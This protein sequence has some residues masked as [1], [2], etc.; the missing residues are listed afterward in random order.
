M[1]NDFRKYPGNLS[2]TV[3]SYKRE[4]TQSGSLMC[5][6]TQGSDDEE[7]ETIH[8]NKN[9]EVDAK[10]QTNGKELF[11]ASELESRLPGKVLKIITVQ[12]H[13]S[14]IFSIHKYKFQIHFKPCECP[15]RLMYRH[16][17]GGG[18]RYLGSH[19]QYGSMVA[20]FS[21]NGD[22]LA[23]Y[24]TTYRRQNH[25]IS[26]LNVNNLKII[27]TLYAHLNIVYDLEWLNENILV[28]VSSDRTAIVWF[29]FDRGEFTLKVIL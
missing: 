28:S 17:I 23:F 16:E 18:K 19:E 6:M 7:L 24:C 10:P 27:N 5:P 14:F 20:K 9:E 4:L 1:P 22:L 15:N 26:I 11:V 25:E 8:D 2:V 29:L 21:T 12:L 13:S 3:G